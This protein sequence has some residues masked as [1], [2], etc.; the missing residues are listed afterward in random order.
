MKSCPTCKAICPNDFVACPNDGTALIDLVEWAEGSVI[1]GKYRIV[2]K[3][4]QGGMGTVYKVVHVAFDEVHA[5]KVI[6]PSLMSDDLFIK[7]FKHEAVITRKL[8]HPNAVRVD[9]IDEAEDGRPIIVMEYIEGQSLKRL[10]K[11]LGPLPVPRVCAIIKQ[12]ASALDAAHRLG[13]IH[14]D[15]KPDN[16]VL[17]STPEGEQAKV[18]DFGIAKL[19]ETRAG[20]FSG[21]TLTEAGSVVGTPAYMSPEQAMGKRGDELDGRSDIYS[22]GV[23]MYQMLSGELPF[24]ADT[25]MA[26]LLAHMQKPPAPI[27]GL[28]PELQIPE[29]IGKLVMKILEK[30]PDNR[31]QNAEFLIHE[32]EA[33]EQRVAW[34]TPG[35][36]L[37]RVAEPSPVKPRPVEPASSYSPSD[38][39]R[40]L[41]DS[42]QPGEPAAR[43]VSATRAAA[44]EPA[45][46]IPAPAP[47]PVPRPRPAP[48]RVEPAP[49]PAPAIPAPA[50]APRPRPA[51]AR[52]EP[53]PRPAPVYAA[54]PRKSQTGVWIAVAV[55]S[56]VLVVLG[57]YIVQRE[58]LNTSENSNS[59]AGQ[60]GPGT[61]A[62]APSQ[63][64]A[65]S[66]PAQPAGNQPAPAAAASGTSTQQQPVQTQQEIT[67]APR[68]G[69]PPAGQRGQRKTAP[70]RENPPR[71]T[72][73]RTEPVRR[74][75]IDPAQI[76][77]AKKL[78]QFYFNRGEY[79]NAIAE[80]QRGLSLDPNDA[81]LRAMLGRAKKAKAAED[82]ILQ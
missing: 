5:L 57:L 78:G 58:Y 36:G 15:I 52:T 30:N 31:P 11:D 73:A 68:G 1:R 53:A 26:M 41:R 46:A 70:G 63:N 20:E 16:I 50:P 39:A 4:G 65:Q 60:S 7:R 69:V 2:S 38:A 64:Q 14:R 54:P 12:V 72:T 27:L 10:I 81:E 79:E 29:P 8:R 17:V 21:L 33:A 47:P 55:L 75:A 61:P 37:T 9:D 6:N 32:I 80:F 43:Q 34:S 59:A 66:Q 23:V 40:A 3:L 22:L 74:P 62:P 51:P 24:K 25:S 42:L 82:K 44:K 18:L 35:L 76:A 49:T 56:I 67:N 45:P 13:M 19:K 48:A 71:R 77:A 28:R